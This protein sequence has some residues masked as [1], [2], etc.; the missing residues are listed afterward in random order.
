MNKFGL[1]T[2][3][4]TISIIAVFLGLTVRFPGPMI[5]LAS[6][7]PLCLFVRYVRPGKGAGAEIRI[8]AMLALTA[9]PPYLAAGPAIYSK[10]S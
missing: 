2:L 1:S 6:F 7:A 10:Y 9:V 4:C 3:L 5:L 8:I